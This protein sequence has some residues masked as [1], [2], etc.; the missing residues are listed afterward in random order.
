[1]SKTPDAQVIN[2]ALARGATQKR[3]LFD[4]AG[5]LLTLQEAARL[6]GFTI[7]VMKRAQF[8]YLSAEGG[9]EGY[10]RFQF[11]S[12]EMKNAVQIV[13]AA[14]GA[15]EPWMQLSFFFLSLDELGGARPVDAIRSG[16]LDAVVVAASHFGCHG[17]S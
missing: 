10:P 12:E 8:I 13:L 3:T 15:E 9:S 6:L 16:K 14:I 7:P 2:D 5:G 1:M 4:Q 17:A 11:E